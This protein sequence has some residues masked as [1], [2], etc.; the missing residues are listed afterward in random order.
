MRFRS[1]GSGWRHQQVH[2]KGI[3]ARQ[4]N[5]PI[6][7]SRQV[8]RLKANTVNNSL[9]GNVSSSLRQVFIRACAWCF[10]ASR[11]VKSR[12]NCA[13]Q[14]ANVPEGGNWKPCHSSG[15]RIGLAA[16][17][18]SETGA[19]ANWCPR[20]SGTQTSPVGSI[21]TQPPPRI[22]SLSVIQVEVLSAALPAFGVAGGL[23]SGTARAAWRF[24][25]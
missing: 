8:D 12:V 25:V 3:E 9:L 20:P 4:A 6:N 19:P 16:T 24:R 15:S 7:L 2:L 10:F 5:Q 13:E 1:R 21:P 23:E 22:P 17:M 18:D 11:S 14:R